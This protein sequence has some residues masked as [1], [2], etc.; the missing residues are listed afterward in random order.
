[1]AIKILEKKKITDQS[2]MD[3]LSREI[4]I[5]K[6]LRHPNIVQLYQVNTFLIFKNLF[7]NLDNRD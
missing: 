7:L 5:L 1:M 3:R 6:Q 4:N 2:D